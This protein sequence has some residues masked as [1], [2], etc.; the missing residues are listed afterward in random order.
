[1]YILMA[2]K[3]KIPP[4]INCKPIIKKDSRTLVWL[5]DAIPDTKINAYDGIVTSIADFE[6]WHTKTS[7]MGLI[8]TSLSPIGF[9]VIRKHKMNLFITKSVFEQFPKE[10]WMSLGVSI[11]VLEELGDQFP[12]V[13][14]PWSGDVVDAVACVTLM[15]HY[16]KL[17]LK[18]ESVLTEARQKQF[19]ENGMTVSTEYVAPPEIWFITQ[20]FVHSVTKRAKEIRQCLKNNLQ[21]K[22]LDKVVLLNEADF[23]YEWSGTKGSEKVQQE[24]IKT[25][26]TYKDLLKY[27]YEQVPPNTIVIFANA[28][29]YC[30]N[31]LRSL[32]S[33]K[34]ND[35][36]YALLR[37]DEQS[38]PEDLKLFGPRAD[39]Q[40]AW[41][42]LSDSIKSRTWTW[43]SFNYQL[44]TAGCDNRFTGD[45]FGMR[46]L[47]SNPCQTIQT[48]HIH[49]TA[50]R[51]YNPQDIVPAKLYMYIHPCSLVEIDQGLEGP[52]PIGS[53]SP[54]TGIVTV[55]GLNAKKLETYCIMLAR[56][57]RF[58]WSEK[59]P[60]H[61]SL[62]PLKT[63]RWSN[64]F[65]TNA[66]VVFDYKKVYLGSPEKSNDFIQKVGRDLSI[67]YI[68]ACDKAQSMLAI[69]CT[70]VARMMNVDLYCLYYLSYA[71]QMYNQL[72]EGERPSIFVMP[73][74]VTTLQGFVLKQG[75]TGPLPAVIWSPT[76][77]VY[78]QN[79][80]GF[81]PE[82]CELSV[83]EIRALRGSWSEWRPMSGTKCVVLV[84]EWL[85]PEFV[86]NSIKP[87]L[88]AGWTVEQVLRTNY[89]LEA[90]RQLAGAGLCILYNLP[91]QEEQYAK[92]WTLPIGCPVLEFQ[93]EL[94]VDGGCQHL[95]AVAELSSWLFPLHKGTPVETR[96][97]I[98]TQL[99]EWLLKNPLAAVNQGQAS[100]CP[101]DMFLSL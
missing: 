56:E 36:L 51:N 70:S 100:S 34:M 78:A 44:G 59:G 40:D 2:T 20:Y 13:Q 7:I 67:S 98:L 75:A 61:L 94:K 87:L 4:I 82:V 41:I 46:F 6:K 55:R 24:I 60:N 49:R 38:G 42:C 27:T 84:D 17:Y 14:N 11:G 16:N 26:L 9:E 96:E 1:V 21:C 23:R 69:P 92:L 73:D 53:L 97:Q 86:E 45:M 62:S 39:S 31:T 5:H 12:V 28:D 74:A 50:I 15:L 54:R 72:P 93:N 79:I 65:V 22:W 89:G 25:R 30:N 91:K 64:S 95:A 33:V 29:I 99:K 35:A 52:V 8:L 10:D 85:T 71:V 81:I 63:Y 83:N 58:K 66:G 18:P 68:H 90:Y 32:Y 3:T 80:V 47:I 57:N 48:V 37:W 77:L 76:G 43:D 88:P 19:N 101:T